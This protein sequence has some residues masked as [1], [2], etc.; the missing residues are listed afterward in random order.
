MRAGA[1]ND[2][3]LGV[4][5]FFQADH[6]DAG[7]P[8]HKDLSAARAAAKRIGLTVFGFAQVCAE[9]FEHP[10]GFGGDAVHA[11]EIA[12]I[13]HHGEK[14]RF[15]HLDAPFG[16]EPVNENRV[17]HA[18]KGAALKLGILVFKG[19]KAV[20]AGRNEFLELILS[21]V[22]DVFGGSCLK[23][24]FLTGAASEVA[25]AALFLHYGKV[26]AGGLENLHH[27]AGNFLRPA[28][29]TG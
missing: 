3:A 15:T 29:V 28:V 14:L 11:S 13:M 26:N 8:V 7:R 2:F 10:A 19:V 20:R 18:V 5:E 6:V 17:A 4:L 22:F 24:V 25:V 21:E 9:G 12:G 23:E 27:G 1:C 16:D